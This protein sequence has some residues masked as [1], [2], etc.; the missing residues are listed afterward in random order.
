MNEAERIEAIERLSEAIRRAT[1][2]HW[3]LPLPWPEFNREARRYARQ[4]RD[5]IPPRS[6]WEVTRNE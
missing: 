3:R 6:L 2:L 1:P 4:L 5:R